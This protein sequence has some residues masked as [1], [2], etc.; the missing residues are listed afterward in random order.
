MTETEGVCA[1][2]IDFD[3]RPK[4]ENR[5][6]MSTLLTLSLPSSLSSSLRTNSDHRRALLYASDICGAV[7]STKQTWQRRIDCSLAHTYARA[8]IH[9]PR[10]E[11]GVAGWLVGW[12]AGRQARD[13]QAGLVSGQASRPGRQLSCS[14]DGAPGRAV[15]LFYL[16]CAYSSSPS[17]PRYLSRPRSTESFSPFLSASLSVVCLSSPLFLSQS[18]LHVHSARTVESLSLPLP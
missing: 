17:T 7:L 16:H 14:E 4:V 1:A 2:S 13:S 6:R 10:R 15:S 3:S 18:S 12:Q 8:R 11:L 9:V 5:E